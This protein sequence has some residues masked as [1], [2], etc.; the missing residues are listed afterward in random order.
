[1]NQPFL[2]LLTVLYLITLYTS[3]CT[4]RKKDQLAPPG[5]YTSNMSYATDIVPILKSNCYLCHSAGNSVGSYG[6]ILDNYDSLLK[7]YVSPYN[8]SESILVFVIAQDPNFPA[9]P[10]M[11]PK[12]DSC[13]IHQIIAWINQG[14]LNN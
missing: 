2:R 3:S 13:S 7:N 12:L 9:M 8:P 14:A 6:H 11:K 5:C 10:Y 1:M 4:S